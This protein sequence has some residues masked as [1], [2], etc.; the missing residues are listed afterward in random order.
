MV[1]GPT[2]KGSIRQRR[3]FEPSI[4]D[5]FQ[6]YRAAHP[7]VY[8]ALVQYAREAKAAGVKV[9]M[10]AIWER[11][12]WEMRVQRRKDDDYLLNNNFTAH[13][14]RE[15]MRL[16]EDLAGFFETRKLRAA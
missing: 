3:L 2:S 7:E 1:T 15:I 13:Y 6:Q 9:G 12:R 4:E 10:K 8:P 5:R 16:E 14:A 11:V